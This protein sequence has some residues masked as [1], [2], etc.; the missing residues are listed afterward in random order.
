MAKKSSARAVKKTARKK[1]QRARTR[2]AAQTITLSNVKRIRPIDKAKIYTGGYFASPRDNLQFINTGSTLLNLALGGGWCEGRVFNIIGDK[3]TGKTLLAIE[4]MANF[5]HKYPKAKARYWESEGAFD[6]DYAEALG[7]PVGRVDLGDAPMATV[8]DFYE[9]LAKVVEEA[10]RPE[11]VILDSLDALSDRAE[12]ERDIDESS[13]G[14]N[15]AKK[16]GEL[17][18]RLVAEMERKQI[19]LGIISQVRDKIN[20][21]FGRKWTRS[22]GKALDFYA[23]QTVILANTGRIEKTTLGIKSVIGVDIHAKMDKNKVGLPYREAKF[24]IR[25]GYGV[26][27][28]QSLVNYLAETKRLGRVDILPKEVNGFTPYLMAK[29]R[30]ERAKWIKL[31]RDVATET[32]YDIQKST[33]LPM[34]KYDEDVMYSD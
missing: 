30:E 15:K 7:M 16:L 23:S 20:A 5:L 24:P 8:E 19:T 1:V 4:A 12:L 31:L 28:I 9:K 3:S 11:L 21:M 32:Y 29:P 14:A 2:P 26:D 10:T 13:Y 22:G 27:E 6:L 33:L 25:F 34:G 18:R 17:F